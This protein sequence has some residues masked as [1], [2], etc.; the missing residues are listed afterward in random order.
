MKA[1]KGTAKRNRGC[2]LCKPHRK[3]GNGGKRWDRA[4]GAV[5]PAKHVIVWINVT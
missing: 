4:L 3:A 5:K 2:G 1:R